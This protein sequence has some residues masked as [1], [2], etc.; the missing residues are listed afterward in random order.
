MILGI[1]L[2]QRGCFVGLVQRFA[3]RVYPYFLEALAKLEIAVKPHTNRILLA[4]TLHSLL[5]YTL[6][7]S[8][9]PS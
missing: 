8:I 3:S 1:N 9:F 5:P 7:L 2:P 6:T 4:P